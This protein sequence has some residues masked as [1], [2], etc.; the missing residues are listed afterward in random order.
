MQAY[1]GVDVLIIDDIKTSSASARAW[2]TFQLMDEFIRNNK[3]VVIAA[4]R[5]P[6]T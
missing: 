2:T 1:H 4:D 5:A 3:K 6:K